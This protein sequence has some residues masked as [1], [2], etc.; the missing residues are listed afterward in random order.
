MCDQREIN[1]EIFN[2]LGGGSRCG[3]GVMCYSIIVYTGLANSLNKPS[4]S[5]AAIINS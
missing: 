2:L 4:V 3:S 5:N 1:V